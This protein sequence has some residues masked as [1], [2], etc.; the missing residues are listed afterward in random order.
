[1]SIKIYNSCE[2]TSREEDFYESILEG[3]RLILEMNNVCG[4]LYLDQQRH[5]SESV[6]KCM[7]ENGI[8]TISRH[9]QDEFI[10]FYICT[11]EEELILLLYGT[12]DGYIVDSEYIIKIKRM[13]PIDFK[14]QYCNVKRQWNYDDDGEFS[15]ET[16]GH[17]FM[18]IIERIGFKKEPSK[19]KDAIEVIQNWWKENTN[20]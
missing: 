18:E 7:I 12:D 3:T 6:K 11:G 15:I 5:S 14:H 4:D 8:E 16:P 19:I 2:G 13:E 1:M 17:K 20:D 10:F 9:T